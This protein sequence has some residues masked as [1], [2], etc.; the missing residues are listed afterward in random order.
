MPWHIYGDLS[1]S[2]VFLSNPW[3]AKGGRS[4]VHGPAVCS[5]AALCNTFREKFKGKFT[6]NA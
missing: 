5:A 1:V 2:S 6:L 3:K 4:G